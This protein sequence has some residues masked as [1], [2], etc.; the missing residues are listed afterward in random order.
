VIVTSLRIER[1]KCV[2]GSIEPY[3]LALPDVRTT[4][5]VAPFHVLPLF[6][7]CSTFLPA[8]VIRATVGQMEAGRTLVR[9]GKTRRE[10][11]KNKKNRPRFTVRSFIGKILYSIANT[12]I[13][14]NTITKRRRGMGEAG[15]KGLDPLILNA[16]SAYLPLRDPKSRRQDTT[17]LRR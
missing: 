4:L 6:P 10:C 2:G 13:R 17:I 14:G 3:D 1:T 7:I 5:A 9:D 16:H 11:R 12:S 8:R 15:R